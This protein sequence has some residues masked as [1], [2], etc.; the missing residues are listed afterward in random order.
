MVGTVLLDPIPSAGRKW[1]D[2]LNRHGFGMLWINESLETI[3]TVRED[4]VIMNR[5]S[6]TDYSKHG[7]TNITNLDA[8][9]L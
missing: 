3:L 5:H 8:Y 7:L 9:V 6:A 2:K 4:L 1:L